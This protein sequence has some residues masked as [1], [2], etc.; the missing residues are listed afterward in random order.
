M[1]LA[2]DYAALGEAV[3]E[4][5]AAAATRMPADIATALEAA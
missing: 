1:S 4:T 2:I 3:Y 5:I